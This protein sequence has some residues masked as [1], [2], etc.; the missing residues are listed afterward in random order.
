MT[1]QHIKNT[2]VPILE[3]EGVVFAGLFGSYSRGEAK[4]ESDVDIVVRFRETKS[5]LQL[6]GIENRLSDALGKKVDLVT[7]K[8]LSPYFREGVLNNLFVLYEG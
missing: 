1:P 4:A 7:E 5:L 6:V 3:K 8:F 2:A